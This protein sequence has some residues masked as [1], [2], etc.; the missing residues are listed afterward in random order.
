MIANPQQGVCRILLAESDGFGTAGTGFV[1]SDKLIVTCAHIVRDAGAGLGDS[2]RIVLHDTGE[3]RQAN[4]KWLSDRDA[5][6]VAVLQLWEPLDSTMEP[7]RLGVFPNVVGRSCRTFGFPSVKSVDG[8]YG[9]ALIVGDTVEAGFPVL[10]L[11]SQEVTAGFSGA[12][13]WDASSQIVIGMVTSIVRAGADPDRRLE[14]TA[15]AI[16]V[17]TLRRVCP[18][19]ELPD[20]CPYRG[21]EPFEIE[22][23]DAYFGRDAALTELYEKL[24]AAPFVAVVGASGSGKSSLVEAGLHKALDEWNRPDIDGRC[25]RFIPGAR[26]LLNLV[27]GLADVGGH[28]LEGLEA[29]LGSYRDAPNEQEI[30]F[31]PSTLDGGD[32]SPESLVEAVGS[33]VPLD[34]L[35]LIVDQ[36]ERLYTDCPSQTAQQFFTDVLREISK[37]GKVII[38]LRADFYGRVLEEASLAGEIMSGQLTLL[39]MRDEELREA[40]VRPADALGRSFAPGLVDRLVTD[41]RGQAGNLPLLE[42]A[43][44]ELWDCDAQN[45]VL[46][47]ESY[48]ALGYS[49]PEREWPGLHGAVAK[50]AEHIYSILDDDDERAAVRR[51]FLGLVTIDSDGH[52][53]GELSPAISRR[54]GQDEWKQDPT[55]QRIIK[56]FTDARLLTTTQDPLNGKATVGVAHEALIQA[57]P[58]LQEWVKKYGVFARWRNHVLAPKLSDWLENDKKSDFLLPDP[59][60]EP[61][62][63]WLETHSGELAGSGAEFIRASEQKQRQQREQELRQ[64]QLD[65]RRGHLYRALSVILT[66]LL[67]VAVASFVEA[68]DAARVATARELAAQAEAN[69]DQQPLSLLLS[70]ESLRRV[71]TGEARDTL[72]QGL[73]Q[74]RHNTLALNGHTGRVFGVAFSPDGATIASASDDQTVRLWDASTGEAIGKP[75]SGHTQ[76]VN[77]VAFSPDGATIASASHDG[78]VRLW[79]RATGSKL[80]VPPLTGHTGSVL[81]VAFSPDGGIIAS[82]SDDQTIR[83]WDASTGEPLGKP[84]GHQVQGANQGINAVA[85]SPDGGIIASASDDQTVRLWDANTGEPLGEPLTGHST[86]VRAVAFSPDGAVLASASDD[87]TVRLWDTAT[88]EPL[89][90]VLGD[91]L[92]A[93]STGHSGWVKGVAFSPDGATIASASADQTIRLWD[94]ATGQPIGEPLTGHTGTVWAVAFSPDGTTVAASD[95]HA[96]RLWDAATGQPIGEPLTG[97]TGTVLGVAFSRDGATIASASADETVRLWDVASGE[98]IGEPLSGHTD[99]VNGVAFSPDGTSIAS[100]SDDNTVRLW[101]AATGEP[102]G[103]P[104][105]GHNGQVSGVAFSPDGMIIASAG[106]DQTVRLWDAATGQAIGESLGQPLPGPVLGVAFSPN[107]AI[108]ASAGADETVRLWDVASGELIGEPLSGHTD[109]INGVAF[110]PDGATI[111]SASDDQTV[112][113]WDAATGKPVGAPLTGHTGPVEDVAFSPDGVIIASAGNDHTVRLWDVATGQTLRALRGHTH[114]V[115]DVVFSPD[116][117]TIA[118]SSIDETV[119]LWEAPSGEPI[120]APLTGHSGPVES[121][122]FSP[123]SAT[124]VSTSSDGTARLWPIGIDAWVQHACALLDRNLQQDEWDEYIG[125]DEPYVRTCLNLPS[126]PG[127][128]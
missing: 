37:R 80:V 1:V 57:W 106:A 34:G 25:C 51:V 123:N 128:P 49:T 58:R 15:F 36:F 85:F 88:G 9:N 48:D 73:L 83:L 21:L 54:A 66:I 47:C 118:S 59:L 91:P 113:L 109:W 40:I 90:K 4:V 78:T 29:A 35:L 33:L 69:A 96:V 77:A 31:E 39:P 97:H 94:A 23:A 30:P 8:L 38:V 27:H 124:M 74:P 28:P 98:L 110:S 115:L 87:Q 72:L 32:S 41:A 63:E 26:P 12:P 11:E 22:H 19:L 121:V 3:Q 7:L 6:D 99:W 82:A 62:C 95:D 52:S 120:G 45:G 119:R 53:R 105:I 75:L 104:L 10:Q 117:A 67:I 70:L 101:N 17:D 111:A 84:L 68:R 108:V 14:E 81:G 76:G 86:W 93:S 116:G 43:L 92:R 102:I 50:R 64:R 16:P 65:R 100:V 122:A 24:C 18:S 125:P 42:F 2:V 79:D 89:G 60:V 103:E 46:T 5:E 20:G 112:R 13:L 126:G 55:A 71:P 44:K 127:A 56:K 114:I 107:G 61:A